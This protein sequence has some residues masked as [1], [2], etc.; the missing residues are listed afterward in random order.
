L[1]GC[2]AKTIEISVLVATLG[3]L[4]AVGSAAAQVIELQGAWVIDGYTF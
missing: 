2:H 4:L 3:A 1:G